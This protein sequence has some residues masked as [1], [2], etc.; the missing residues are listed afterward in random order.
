MKN[1]HKKN[2][3]TGKCCKCS[4]KAVAIYYLKKYCSSHARILKWELKIKLAE[5]KRNGN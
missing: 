2:Q 4:K 1:N 3:I 5:E